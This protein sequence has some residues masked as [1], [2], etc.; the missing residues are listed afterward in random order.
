MREILSIWIPCIRT[1]LYSFPT[2]LYGSKFHEARTETE[3]L[4]IYV[5]KST[6]FPH[7][8]VNEDWTN[9]LIDIAYQQVM[10]GPR[11]KPVL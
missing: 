5:I 4:K 6:S 1:C 8:S 3:K 7:Y 10:S 11:K 2:R 9:C